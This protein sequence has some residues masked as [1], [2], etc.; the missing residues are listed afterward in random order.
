MI[1][2]VIAMV[3]SVVD[4]VGIDS[5]GVSGVGDCRTG[6]GGAVEDGKG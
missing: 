1:A 2:A 5:T 3:V 6:V 4:V